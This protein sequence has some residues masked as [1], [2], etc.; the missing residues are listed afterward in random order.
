MADLLSL[1]FNLQRN[2]HGTSANARQSFGFPDLEDYIDRVS[3]EYR[4][5]KLPFIYFTERHDRSIHNACLPCQSGCDGQSQQPVS[6][7]LA[8]HGCLAEFRVGM[9]AVVVAG[10]G[11]K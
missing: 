5:D 10:E 6:N 11:G 7:L 8:E 9:D 4:F 2:G 3:N 1:V